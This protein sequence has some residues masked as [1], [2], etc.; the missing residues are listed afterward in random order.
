MLFS[1]LFKVFISIHNIK[2][3]FA[4]ISASKICK[5]FIN[6]YIPS[7]K[8]LLSVGV[9]PLRQVHVTLNLVQRNELVAEEHDTSSRHFLLG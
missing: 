5:N 6:A 7:R 4:S 2:V 9:Y 1:H 3:R 8:Y